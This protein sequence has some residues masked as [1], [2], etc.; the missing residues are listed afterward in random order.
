[1]D[2]NVLPHRSRAVIECL[3]LNTVSTIPWPA[4]S[5]NLNIE[6]LGRKVSAMNLPA[7]NLAEMVAVA[8]LHRVWHQI[9]Q[10]LIQ[11]LVQGI[12]RRLRAVIDVRGGHTRY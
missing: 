10:R 8:A 6:I 1:M 7:Q 5:P 9:P 12:W 3:C 2:G 4:H 11:R